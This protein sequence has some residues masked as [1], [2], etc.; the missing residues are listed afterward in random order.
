MENVMALGKVIEEMEDLTVINIKWFKSEKYYYIIQ[1]R[2]DR[3]VF[4]TNSSTLPYSSIFRFYFSIS[5]FQSIIPP[6]S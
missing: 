5:Y 4:Y 2:V 3:F 6:K 1:K